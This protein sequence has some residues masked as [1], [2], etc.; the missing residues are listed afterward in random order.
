MFKIFILL[1]L[2]GVAYPQACP[3]PFTNNYQGTVIYFNQIYSN[4]FYN[5][6]Y[7]SSLLKIFNY[8]Y[9]YAGVAPS[10]LI[11]SQ[12]CNMPYSMVFIINENFYMRI[13]R[14]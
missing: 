8:C 1:T 7:F 4:F 5:I 9:Y 2:V 11:A 10:A 14:D 3:Y 6:Y 12:M 13:L